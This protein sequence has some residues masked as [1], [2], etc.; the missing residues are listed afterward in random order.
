MVGIHSYPR[1]HEACR[2]R[3]PARGKRSNILTWVYLS[4]S[5]NPISIYDVLEAMCELVGF[6]VRWG[7]LVCL[8]PVQDGGDSR[9]AVFLGNTSNVKIRFLLAMQTHTHHNSNC[10]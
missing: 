7:G 1:A 6:V 4:V 8:H 9:T 2:L 5:P 10:T 3:T